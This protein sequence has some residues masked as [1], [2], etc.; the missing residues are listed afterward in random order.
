[1]CGAQIHLLPVH[2][3]FWGATCARHR[4][5]VLPEKRSIVETIFQ[6][7]TASKPPIFLISIAIKIVP[8]SHATEIKVKLVDKTRNATHVFLKLTLFFNLPTFWCVENYCA[9]SVQRTS[10]ETLGG[11]VT[12]K[13]TSDTLNLTSK[14]IEESCEILGYRYTTFRL[15]P[16]FIMFYQNLA[17]LVILGIIP[18]AMLIFFNCSIYL[19]IKRRRGKSYHSTNLSFDSLIYKICITHIVL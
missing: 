16:Y 2:K 3:F 14:Q 1:M 15:H 12:S 19:A 5:K 17:R 9:G 10:N 6:V 7:E 11:N 18:F 13:N 8:Q 4:K